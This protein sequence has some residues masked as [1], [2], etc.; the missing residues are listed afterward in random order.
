MITY[1]RWILVQNIIISAIE[2][3]FCVCIAWYEHERDWENSRQPE[4]PERK[5]R[6]CITVEKFPNPSSVYTRLC[7]PRKKVFYCF[8]KITSSTKYNAGKDKKIHFTDQNISSYNID[9]TMGFLNWSI[10]ITFWKSGGGVFTTRVSLRH[11][12]MFT[13]SHANMPLSQSEHAY[14]LSYFIKY[15]ITLSSCYQALWRILLAKMD[16]MWG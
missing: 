11:T 15:Y 13:Y 1:S 3:V 4:K 9:L 6:V 2:N 5:S 10:K 14:Y 7:K 16:N 8:S 12:T